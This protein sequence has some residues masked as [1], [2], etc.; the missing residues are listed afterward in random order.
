MLLSG[1]FTV[2]DNDEATGIGQPALSQPLAVLRRASVV[3]T[4]KVENR[5]SFSAPMKRSRHM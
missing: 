2:T 4:R 1:E 3:E 5:S